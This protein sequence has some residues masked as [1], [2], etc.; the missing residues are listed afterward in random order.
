LGLD[1]AI[2][3]HHDDPALPEIVHFGTL[4]EQAYKEDPTAPKQIILTPG[5]AFSLPM[6]LS[7]P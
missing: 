5:Q 7:R 6:G 3:C 2:P 1:H 4:L